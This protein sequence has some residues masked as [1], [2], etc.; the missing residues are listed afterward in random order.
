M[1]ATP[2]SHI[3]NRH[4]FV[5][6]LYPLCNIYALH[7]GVEPG[8]ALIGKTLLVWP[9]SMCIGRDQQQPN[10]CWRTIYIACSMFRQGLDSLGEHI[11]RARTQRTRHLE[12][13]DHS[14]SEHAELW[15]E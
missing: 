5:A 12:Q 11:R 7:A 6:A 3:S 13:T 15:S 10:C 1:A 8:L 2:S 14:L 4:T 9:V